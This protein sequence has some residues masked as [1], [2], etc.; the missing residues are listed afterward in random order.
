MATSDATTVDKFALSKEA[1]SVAWKRWTILVLL[2]LGAVIAFASRTNIPQAQLYKSFIQQFHLSKTDLGVVNSAFF[3]SY[4][5]L[6]IPMG[7]IVDRY[8]TKIPYAIS[9]V[10]W[11]LGSAA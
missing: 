8:G 7:W 11:C 3:W 4:M 9:F 1:E 5:V 2:G 6:Q 10:F